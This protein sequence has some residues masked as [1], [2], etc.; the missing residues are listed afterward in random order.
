MQEQHF[1]YQ[2]Q[3]VRRFRRVLAG[4]SRAEIFREAKQPARRMFTTQT[5]RQSAERVQRGSD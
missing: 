2:W 5:C 4:T 1:G 3:R